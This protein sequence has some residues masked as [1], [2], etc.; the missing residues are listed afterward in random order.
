MD[1]RATSRGMML[2]V[3]V[4]VFGLLTL[5][6]LALTMVSERG[7][8]AVRERAR[9]FDALEQRI[10]EL[11]AENAAMLEEIGNLNDPY[12]GEVERRAREELNLVRP[13][14]VILAVPSDQTAPPVE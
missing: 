14:E 2:R 3:G 4:A 10:G 1:N 12:G 11:E 13:G 5:A 9:E 8:F 6:I 7:F